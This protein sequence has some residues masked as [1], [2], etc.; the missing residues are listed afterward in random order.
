MKSLI[1]YYPELREILPNLG[2]HS[3]TKVFTYLH[4]I[5]VHYVYVRTLT[6]ED[7]ITETIKDLMKD[8][9]CGFVFTMDV[10]ILNPDG[11]KA[12]DVIHFYGLS[13]EDLIKYLQLKVFS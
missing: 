3:S 2:F 9:E 10:D 13:K 6:V 4:Q 5:G 7:K 1:P 8:Q 12:V 11:K